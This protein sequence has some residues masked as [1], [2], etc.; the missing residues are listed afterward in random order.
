MY[1]KLVPA[2]I[3]FAQTSKVQLLRRMGKVIS[4]RDYLE[5]G[6]RRSELVTLKRP[7]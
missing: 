2:N 1:K 6:D 3:H 7:T 4:Y 5:C